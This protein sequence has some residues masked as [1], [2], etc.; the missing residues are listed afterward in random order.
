MESF[1]Y[2]LRHGARSLWKSKGLSFIAAISLAAGI[3]ANSA[4]FSI[5]NSTLLRPRPFT[6]PDQLLVLYSGYRGSPYESTSYP[7]YADFRERNGVFTDLAAYNMGWQLRLAGNDEVDQVWAEVVSGNFFNVLGV[8]TQ[9]GRPFLPEEDEV[10]GRNPVVI[11]GHALWQRRFG[12]DSSVIGRTAT[13]NNQPFTIVGVMPPTFTGMTSGWATEVWVPLMATTLLD[14]S[15][16]GRMS[17]RGASW[18]TMVGRLNPG[19]TIEQ[20]RARFDLLATE[21][22][23]EQPDEWIDT[24]GGRVRERIVTVL[25]ERE[26]RIHP[27]MQS[28]GMAIS[29]LVFVVVD[30]V[31]VIACMNLASLLFARGVARRSE[32]ALRLALGASRLRIVR[33]LLAESLLLSLAAG[34]VGV[35]FSLWGLNALLAAMPQL[36]EGIRLAINPAVDW[37]VVSFSI[38]FAMITGVLF[39]LGPALKSSK[40]GV[41]SAMKDDSAAYTSQFT[42]SRLRT[43]L[44]VGQVAFSMLLLIGAGLILRS[45]DKVRPTSLGYSSERVVVAP[46]SLDEGSYDRLKSQAFY[47]ELIS[48]L[49]SMPGVQS[50]SLVDG[51]PGGFMSRSRRSTEIEGYAARP[52]DDL[53]IDANIV[54]AGY[55]TNLNVPFVVGRDFGP[56]D[57]DG[58]PCVSIVNEAFAKRYLGNSAQAIG[59]HLTRFDGSRGQKTMCAIVGVIRDNAWQSLQ[60]EPRPLYAMSLLQSHERRMTLLVNTAGE[61]GTF[62]APVRQAIRRLDAGMP[63]S[64]VQTLRD[65][66]NA[67]ALPFTALGLVMSAC[68][69]LALILASVG[70]YGTIAYSVAQRKREVGI[71][72]ALGAVRR[73]ILG[74]VVGQGMS[75]V[76]IGLAIGLVLGLA[77]TRVLNSLPLDMELLFGISATDVLTFGGVTALLGVVA[78][79]ACYVPAR[80]AASTDPMVTLRNR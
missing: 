24:D 43:S 21:M 39:G 33:Q 73:D 20:A 11:I 69:L 45:L 61:P 49:S 22:R 60:R 13:F 14:P 58:A 54:S 18:L 76:S 9:L 19:T 3:G 2:D 29:L 6:A 4:I 37:K 68:G 65:S 38:A 41:A 47:R 27:Q 30:L 55:F 70:I 5:V 31:L 10:A 46:V 78:L 63:L 26:T 67:M 23:R 53:E 77:L 57:I 17:N 52:G 44:V 7:S 56:Q 64:G 42:K 59:R 48:S 12:G 32:V 66:Y 72:M 36:P 16:A 28:L 15:S 34:V 74:L 51:L 35:V 40:A 1:L 71:R 50:V 8:R 80:R 62:V 75:L 79:L 25:P